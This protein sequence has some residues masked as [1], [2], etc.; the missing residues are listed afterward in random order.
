[1]LTCGS[2][3]KTKAYQHGED[4]SLVF[5]HRQVAREIDVTTRQFAGTLLGIDIAELDESQIAVAKTVVVHKERHEDA[6]DLEHQILRL[7]TVE[8]VVVEMER[9]LSLYAMSLTQAAYLKNVFSLYH[10]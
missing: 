3:D 1:M 6:I 8:D 2:I 10:D 4:R 7:H 9:H 5:I